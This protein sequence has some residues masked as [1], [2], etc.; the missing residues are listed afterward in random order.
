MFFTI[1]ALF[2]GISVGAALVLGGLGIGALIGGWHVN[3]LNPRG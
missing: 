1:V 3:E 2:G